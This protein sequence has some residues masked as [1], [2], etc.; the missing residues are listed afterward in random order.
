MNWNVFLHTAA[1]C[2]LTTDLSIHTSLWIHRFLTRIKKREDMKFDNF[3]G[4]LKNQILKHVTT[5]NTAVNKNIFGKTYSK[6]K[7]HTDAYLLKVYCLIPA[8]VTVQN[9]NIISHAD[10]FV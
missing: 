3:A 2:E 10:S 4:E 5:K 6:N 7:H 8:S 1:A 9:F